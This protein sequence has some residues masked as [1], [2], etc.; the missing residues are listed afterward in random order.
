MYLKLRVVC[1]G[2]VYGDESTLLFYYYYYYH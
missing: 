1:W 2:G